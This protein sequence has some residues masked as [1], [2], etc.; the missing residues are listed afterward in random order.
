MKQAVPDFQIKGR[1][2]VFA[3]TLPKEDGSAHKFANVLGRT[4]PAA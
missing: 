3:N 1:F 2:W 4:F